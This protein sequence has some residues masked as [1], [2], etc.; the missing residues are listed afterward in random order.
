MVRIYKSSHCIYSHFC[1]HAT[2]IPRGTWRKVSL[3]YDPFCPRTPVGS[4]CQCENSC[5][6]GVEITEG[7]IHPSAAVNTKCRFP[8][9][10]QRVP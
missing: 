7:P 10:Q 6:E 9:S 8:G 5:S 3:F 4:R 2:E 1:I